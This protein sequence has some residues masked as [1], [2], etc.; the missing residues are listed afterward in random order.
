MRYLLLTISL[1]LTSSQVIGQVPSWQW[2]KLG[3]SIG[4]QEGKSAVYDPFNNSAFFT[5]YLS[6]TASFSGSTVISNGDDDVFLARY[7]PNG[8][9]IWAKNAGSTGKDR[10]EGIC[11]DK[12]GNVYLTGFF[13]N[14]ITFYGA[15][16]ITLTS[17]GLEDMFVAKYDQN[18]QVQWAVKFGGTGKDIGHS[19]A[20]FG[21][22]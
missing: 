22:D 7:A 12:L 9:L 20:Y 6:D 8:Q 18:G 13:S 11:T 10:A 21:G 16:N 5:G 1:L 3:A 14:T 19:I 4:F 15:P 2:V 17:A